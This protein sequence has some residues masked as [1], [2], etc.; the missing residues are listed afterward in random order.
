MGAIDARVALH[1]VDARARHR[2]AGRAVAPEAGVNRRWPA[3]LVLVLAMAAFVAGSVWRD[4]PSHTSLR[5]APLTATPQVGHAAAATW[6]CAAGTAA[7]G[8]AF[9]STVLIA[10]V[11]AQ[12]RHG[13]ITW[14]PSAGNPVPLPFTVPP[15]SVMSFR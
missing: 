11:D 1:V 15:N 5:T 13:I 10:S 3:L 4:P 9:N 8:A 7:A 2:A 14:V 6:Y 12:P